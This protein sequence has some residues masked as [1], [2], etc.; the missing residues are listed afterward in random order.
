MVRRAFLR[1]VVDSIPFVRFGTVPEVNVLLDLAH[2]QRAWLSLGALAL[3]PWVALVL[4]APLRFGTQ[5]LVPLE[6]IVYLA[7]ISFGDQVSGYAG[8][9]SATRFEMYFRRSLA[10]CSKAEAAGQ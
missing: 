3:S 9:V 2:R 4:A 1:L 10:K 6:V 7:V 8:F 5:V